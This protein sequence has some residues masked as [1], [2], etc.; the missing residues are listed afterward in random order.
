MVKWECGLR[1][2]RWGVLV[3]M[4]LRI[5]FLAEDV[6]SLYAWTLQ[7]CERTLLALCSYRALAVSGAR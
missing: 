1:S 6:L 5:V 3:L 4:K 2:S 7:F